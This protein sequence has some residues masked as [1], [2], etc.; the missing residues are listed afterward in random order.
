MVDTINIRVH[1]ASHY[2]LTIYFDRLYSGQ[3]SF[4]ATEKETDTLRDK[5]VNSVLFN[6]SSRYL[7]LSK[8][9]RLYNPTSNY[10][11]GYKVDALRDFIEF[12]FSVP[13]WKYSHN[14][15][16]L[17]DIYNLDEWGAYN[18]L[19]KSIHNFIDKE[20]P[21]KIDDK[22]IEIRRIDL[23]YNQF[24]DNPA[25]VTSYIDAMKPRFTLMAKKNGAVPVPYDGGI[26]YT[27]KRMSFKVYHK[28][29]EFRR[30]DY[31]KLLEA[32]IPGVDAEALAV[33][34]DRVLRYEITFR[35]SYLNYQF[36]KMY[37]FGSSRS[38]SKFIS[39]F[40][41]SVYR[42]LFAQLRVTPGKSVSRNF[43]LASEYDNIRNASVETYQKILSPCNVTFDSIF[44]NQ[45][46][47]LFWRSVKA[48]Q[49]TPSGDSR[50][51][52]E[53]LKKHNKTIAV[54]NLWRVKKHPLVSEKRALLWFHLSSKSGGLK[55]SVKTGYLSERNYYYI[56]KVFRKL[57][58]SDYNPVVTVINPSLTYHD[59][60]YYFHHLH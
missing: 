33:L 14:I 17:I 3:T 10:Y 57:G 15:A 31:Y 7:V 6:D 18:E 44:F 9:D 48:V 47:K 54:D 38:R 59:Y 16:Q 51:F 60:K 24:F 50:M 26:H 23:C 20:I 1:D 36:Y 2:G 52:L 4:S 35:H 11:V 37:E 55:K 56:L 39:P 21:V 42:K 27:T 29:L 40:R 22:H 13:K 49:V 43:S 12:E 8:R 25:F 53:R 58:Y 34:A 45:L 5:Q 30:K 28:G 41:A 46:Y 19:M 32:G